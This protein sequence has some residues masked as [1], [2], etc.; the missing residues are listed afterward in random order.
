MRDYF[1]KLAP[2][3]FLFPIDGDCVNTADGIAVEG[4]IR[5]VATVQSAPGC[6][7]TIGGVAAAEQNGVY[8]AE[9]EVKGRRTELVAKNHTDGTRAVVAVYFM[10][11]ATGKFRLS[12]DDNVIFLWDIT[13]NKDVYTSIFDNPYLAV[14]KK[15]HDLYGAKIHLNLF[16][17]LDEKSASKFSTERPLFNLSMVRDKFK[18]EWRA[19]ADWLKLS[20]HAKSEY[21]NKPYQFADAE[22]ITRDYLNV[23]RE[24][25]RFA[26]EE[27]F[28]DVT[29]VHWGEANPDCVLALRNL[30]HRALTGYF[31]HTAKGDPLVAY[32]APDDLIDHVGARDFFV[33][34][35][36]GM[37]FGRIDLVLNSK[38]LEWVKEELA[39]ILDDPHRAGFVSVMIH[40]QYFYPDY[41]GYLPDFEQRVLEAARMIT[42]RGNVGS[43]VG[44]VID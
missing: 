12:S 9:V 23:R 26:G 41:K 22:T 40:E 10:P 4:G 29:T 32:Y 24:V 1:N 17:E 5:L 35:A 39:K 31:E 44:D 7:V 34:T 8:S 18:D 14:Y 25:L 21:P 11:R 37:T 6:R 3:R 27:V 33:D 13:V 16:Y 2:T 30:G 28:S 36:M 38:T 19:N 42:E 20:F 43:F 15:A